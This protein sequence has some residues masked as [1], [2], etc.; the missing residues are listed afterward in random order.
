MDKRGDSPAQ[1]DGLASGL[2]CEVNVSVHSALE[3]AFHVVDYPFG[4]PSGSLELYRFVIA[5]QV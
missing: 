2:G 4:G 5:A 1:L 3:V